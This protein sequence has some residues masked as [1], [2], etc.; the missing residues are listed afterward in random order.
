MLILHRQ[1]TE[2]ILY[3]EE[4]IDEDEVLAVVVHI[5]DVGNKE[6]LNSEFVKFLSLYL[7]VWNLR[8]FSFWIKKYVKLYV[9]TINYYMLNK[10]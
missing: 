2:E 10:T 4:V 9:I 7:R 3:I 8:T 5:E 1:T 6:K